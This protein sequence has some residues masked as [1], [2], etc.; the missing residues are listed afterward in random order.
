[1]KTILSKDNSIIKETR[2]LKEKKHRVAKSQF[3]VE[4]FR[5]V[6]E[7]IMSDFIVDKIFLHDNSLGKYKELQIEHMLNSNTE[8]FVISEKIFNNI[9]STDTPQG[10]IAILNNRELDI[11]NK[12]G[13]Y[14]LLDKL[15][16]PGN[17]GTIIRTAH[18]AGALGVIVSKG[19]VDIY[20]EKTLRSTMGS[21]FHV[22]I[23]FDN[24][25]TII[26]E[27]RENGFK[28]ISSSLE[29]KDNLYDIDLKGKIIIAIGNEGNGISQQVYEI[30]DKKFKIPMPGNAE[31]LNA[32]IAAS[33]I[34][35]ELVRQNIK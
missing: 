26:K 33:I 5:F 15:Q 35:F 30:S 13:F 9:S 22:P 11:V 28:L 3:I 10:I 25:F 27:L 1:M 32:A 31:S 23:L 19:T 4:G 2:K 29:G 14:I 6:L 20:N 24:N 7:A 12:D 8:V 18:A 34:M 21:I 16:D 17:V